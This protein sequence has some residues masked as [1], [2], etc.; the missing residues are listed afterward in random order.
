MY[1]LV[2]TDAGER[3]AFDPYVIARADAVS[4]EES[5]HPR[6]NDGQFTKGGGGGHAA[7]KSRSMLP[8]KG[9]G[10]NRTQANGKP[11]PS[12]IAALKIPPGWTDVQY[13]ADPTADLLVYG[14]DSKNRPVGIRSKTAEAKTAAQKFAR[15]K[16]LAK[17]HK[18]VQ[19]RNDAARQ[20]PSTRDVA[21]CLDLVLKMG[22]RPGSERDTGAE[23]QA[24]GATTLQGKHVVQNS[25]GTFLRF[26]G[27]KGVKINLAVDDKALAKGLAAR[28]KKAGGSGSLFNVNNQALLR[29]MRTVAGDDFKTK[30]LRTHIGTST[31]QQLVKSMPT[32]T[33][34]KEAQAAILQVA[35]A[36]S[37]KLGN[38]PTIALQSYIAP[39]VFMGWKQ[40][41]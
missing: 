5:E 25:Q 16:A 29:H 36:V 35:K 40:A 2:Q 14:R 26:T 10:K 21:D 33:N 38:T 20:D 41:A 11:L 13:D 15:V 7:S 18:D 32:P 34:A 24:Y 27:K 12:H 3:W 19:A 4:F 31:A 30:D 1:R 6:D 23:V 9:E 17:I 37:A 8:T 28:A 39:E 22:L